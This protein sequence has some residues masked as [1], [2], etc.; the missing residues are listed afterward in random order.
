MNRNDKTVYDGGA[1]ISDINE[2]VY[3]SDETIAEQNATVSSNA[4]VPD[5][6]ASDA[7][8]FEGSGATLQVNASLTENTPNEAADGIAIEKGATLLNTY[9]VESDEIRGGM[10]KVWRVHHLS[11]NT[12][13]AMKQPQA[14]AFLTEQHKE[15]F[16]RECESWIN[17]GLHPHIVSCYYVRE[18]ADIPTIFSEWMDGGSLDDA[19]RIRLEN[20][21]TK[22]GRLYE[23]GAEE[24]ILDIAIQF[25]RGLH[26]AHEQ[27]LI[28]QDVKPA[29]LLLS[30]EGEAKVADF[31]IARATVA[32][33]IQSKSDMEGATMFSA[34]GGYTPEYCS[35][36]QMSG[37]KL[38][39]RTDI[40]SWGGGGGGG[41]ISDG[42][43]SWEA[44]VA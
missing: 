18:I 10:G 7:T 28:H 41:G 42:D 29:N 35:P 32:L 2:T 20:N 37:Q 15:N 26:F 30:Q 39:R 8:L 38:T 21:R 24:R 36:E 13:L 14:K 6:G 27:G 31:G 25:A 17:L 11:W 16:V 22:A 4:K 9:R 44:P 33:S 43:V 5:K 1:T 23:R 34:A 3:D 12:D 40:Y 19:I